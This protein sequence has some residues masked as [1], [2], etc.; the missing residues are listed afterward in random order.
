MTVGSGAD[1]DD[2]DGHHLPYIAAA[3]AC[4]SGRYVATI[5]VLLYTHR[6]VGEVLDDR[7]GVLVDEGHG[8]AVERLEEDERNG[9][10]GVALEEPL[11]VLAVRERHGERVE[12]GGD[13]DDGAERV[14][15][16]VLRGR[17]HR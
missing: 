14:H 13:G 1:N 12:V 3:Y 15:D 2:E 6:R 16:R 4:I 7:V 17:R 8:E 10:R 5:Y 11:V 9:E